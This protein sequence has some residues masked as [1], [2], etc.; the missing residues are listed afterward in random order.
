MR[1]AGS[2]ANT[3]HRDP[4]LLKPPWRLATRRSRCAT[5]LS[6]TL[7]GCGA[8]GAATQRT[9]REA[10]GGG[11][12][13]AGRRWQARLATHPRAG[14]L[15]GHASKSALARGSTWRQWTARWAGVHREGRPPAGAAS[16]R[17]TACPPPHPPHPTHPPTQ[18][19]SFKNQ[20]VAVCRNCSE[21]SC[22]GGCVDF[23]G[24]AGC[25]PGAALAPTPLSSYDE[26]GGYNFLLAVGCQNCSTREW[27]YCVQHLA[28]PARAPL[29]APTHLAA[30]CHHAQPS[31]ARPLAVEGCS[32]L[33]CSKPGAACTA[34]SS[35]WRQGPGP[36]LG[37][38]QTLAFCARKCTLASEGCTDCHPIRGCLT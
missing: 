19:N 35:G 21:L 11:A 8:S 25:H 37:G 28:A 14:C 32:G 1:R 17:V 34:C 16:R 20:R 18:V 13:A 2:P 24:C 3:L 29:R 31:H 6:A 10:L 38:N 9:S 7:L 12:A 4:Q 15:R 36:K 27:S 22:G 23:Q 33:D 5:A 30:T 26:E